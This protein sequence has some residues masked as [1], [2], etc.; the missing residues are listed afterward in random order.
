VRPYVSAVSLFLGMSVLLPAAD[1]VQ[2]AV[3]AVGNGHWYQLVNENLTWN[4][5]R[6][7]A[8]ALGG[9]LATLTSAGEN[10]WVEQNVLRGAGVGENAWIGGADLA[11]SGQW[12]WVEGP[13]AGQIFWTRSSGALAFTNWGTVNDPGSTN[14]PNNCCAGPEYWLAINPISGRW[15]DLF[16]AAV[17]FLVEFDQQPGAPVCN[18]P[19]KV[20]ATE[21][22][23]Q[24]QL[25]FPTINNE[26]LEGGLRK[27]DVRIV[28]RLRF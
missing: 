19:S 6:S 21:D 25:A 5:A 15:R 1:P 13:E 4:E 22:L 27:A 7:R 12:S 16:N 14:E 10:N 26:R 11:L 17:P 28:N 3:A 8:T 9:Y 24:V 2:W 23:D 20:S 18:P